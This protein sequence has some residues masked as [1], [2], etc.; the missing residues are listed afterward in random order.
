[1]NSE[2]ELTMTT[3]HVKKR[4]DIIVE[5]PLLRSII[6][7]LDQ[8]GVTGYSVLPILEGR[9]MVNTWSAEGQI[10]DTTTMVDLFCIVDAAQVDA[11]IGAI[12]G[13]VRAHIGF[14][15]VSDVSVVRPERF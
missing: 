7:R 8:A 13:P 4:I 11:I 1:V 5:T 6:G 12:I 3:Y 2:A 9:G 15:T 14:L 10:S